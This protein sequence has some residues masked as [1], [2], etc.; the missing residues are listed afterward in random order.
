MQHLQKTGGGSL[1]SSSTLPTFRRSDISTFTRFFRPLFRTFEYH[2]QLRCPDVSAVLVHHS[3][4]QLVPPRRQFQLP[5]LRKPL[6]L[7]ACKVRRLERRFYRHVFW[8]ASKNG[9]VHRELSGSAVA[10]RTRLSIDGRIRAVGQ[11]QAGSA[12]A[13]MTFFENKEIH[14]TSPTE[15]WRRRVEVES[16]IRPAKDRIAGFEG[17]GDHRTPFA[18]G[19]SIAGRGAL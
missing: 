12:S 3:E 14:R 2:R 5:M 19:R 1:L 18:S 7:N 6:L 4:P 10:L 9:R 11:G 15:H 13:T 16:T 8:P 17:R